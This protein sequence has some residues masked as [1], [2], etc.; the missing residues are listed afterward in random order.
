VIGEDRVSATE[1]IESR[2]SIADV[3]LAFGAVATR[4]L[5]V[6]VAGHAL[7]GENRVVSGRTFGDPTR[8]GGVSDSSTIDFTAL[9]VSAGV[10]VT[11]LRGVSVGGSA[12]RGGSLRARRADTTLTRADAPDRYGVGRARSRDGAT[13]A[14]GWSRTT[15]TNMRTLADPRPGR[16]AFDV[17]DGDE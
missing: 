5:R 1:R 15:W 10:E 7:T 12:R 16:P 9:A 11:P 2:G 13:F 14:A 6:G 4:W 17:K 3:R 8:F